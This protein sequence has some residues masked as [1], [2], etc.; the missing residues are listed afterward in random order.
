M[1]GFRERL[2]SLSSGRQSRIVLALDISNPNTDKLR[3]DVKDLLT[4]TAES[5]V[6]LKINY[7]LI[8]PFSKKEITE[9]ITL[10]HS[11]NLEVIADL[12]LNDIAPTNINVTSFLWDVGF[13]AVIANPIAGFSGGLDVVLKDAHLNGKG[14]IVLVYMSNSGAT[15]TYGLTVLSDGK[16]SRLYDEFL[17][18]ALSWGADGVVVGGTQLDVLRA[19]SEIVADRADIFSPGIGVQGGSA[20]E[21]VEAGAN[22]IIV[23]RSVVGAADPPRAATEIRSDSW[24]VQQKGTRSLP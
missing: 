18:R 2:S 16:E 9:I 5:I 8:L 19:V 3:R 7:H 14:V 17:R 23:G 10:A 1:K 20:K 4:R 11:H 12:K 13:D 21:V 22:Y 15:E 24:I 6:A